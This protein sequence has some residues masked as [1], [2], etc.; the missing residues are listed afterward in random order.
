MTIALAFIL[1]P[2]AVDVLLLMAHPR[3]S[4]PMQPESQVPRELREKVDRELE[5]GEHVEWLQMPV[6]RYF[7]PAATVGFLFGIPWTAFAIFWTGGAAW[8]TSKA[9]GP[10][11]FSA[12]PLFGLPFILIGF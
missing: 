3:R 2:T 12:F 8:G 1:R 10:G 7:T 5:S 9:G 11:V 4:L 6:P